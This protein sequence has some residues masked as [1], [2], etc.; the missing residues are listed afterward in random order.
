MRY[1]HVLDADLHE[2]MAD[3]RLET[4]TTRK[5]KHVET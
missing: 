4:I 3:F 2:A 5:M 1:A